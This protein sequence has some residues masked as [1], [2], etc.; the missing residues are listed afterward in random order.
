MLPGR[1][2]VLEKRCKGTYYFP[3]FQIFPVFFCTFA[4]V[5]QKMYGNKE[6]RILAQCP[7]GDNVPKGQQ[8]GVRVYRAL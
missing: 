6:G 4:P 5:K 8:A 2:Q 7:N 1:K 3:N